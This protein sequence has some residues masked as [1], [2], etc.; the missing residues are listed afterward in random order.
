MVKDKVWGF[1]LNDYE[2]HYKVSV[3]HCNV[4]YVIVKQLHILKKVKTLLTP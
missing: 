3:R 2:S 1:K 4:L